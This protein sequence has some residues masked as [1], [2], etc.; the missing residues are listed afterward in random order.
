M[1]PSVKAD[2][3]DFN[4]TTWQKSK[5]FA[6]GRTIGSDAELFLDKIAEWAIKRYVEREL[7]ERLP[8]L[9]KIDDE[10]KQA[11][12]DHSQ[13]LALQHR[14]LSIINDVLY[15]T[16][17][18][19]GGLKVKVKGINKPRLFYCLSH[20]CIK[21]IHEKTIID[22]I[23]RVSGEITVH[24]IIH[25]MHND[26][27]LTSYF[28]HRTI[29]PNEYQVTEIAKYLANTQD[30]HDDELTQDEANV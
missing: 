27:A 7:I 19:C 28:T 23:L 3:L 8:E 12:K 29:V 9:E 26:D 6:G 25:A 30:L 22:M 17:D 21:P 5:R 1:L 14:A 20:K 10:L 11:D 2:W 4:V 18:I 15:T 16:S 24:E 13:Q